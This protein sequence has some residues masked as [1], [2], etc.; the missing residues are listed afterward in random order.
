MINGVSSRHVSPN[1]KDPIFILGIL[2]RSGTNFL[3]N[4]L[5]L[6]PNCCAPVPV[7]EDYLVHYS[8]LLVRYTNT[9]FKR[10][11]RNSQEV[12]ARLADQFLG[13]L[14]NGM[15]SLLNSL[16]GDKRLVTKTPS[17]YNLEYFFKLFPRARLLIIVR[18]GRSLVESAVVSFGTNYDIAM[19]KWAD[20][21]HTILQFDQ[22]NRNSPFRYL[23]V[24]YE[25]LNT[26]LE[27][28]MGRILTY[29][30]L[31]P[32][33]YDFNAAVNLP[34][35]GSSELRQGGERV[36]HWDAVPKTANFNPLGRW[37]KWNRALHERFNW[38]AGSYQQQ[39]G[40]GVK[41]YEGNRGLWAMWN[42]LMDIKL[43]I[44]WQLR[45][46]KRTSVIRQYD[47]W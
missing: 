44:K 36:M 35:R 38:I 5:L 18:D 9:V 31:N 47:P 33:I 34:V 13:S 2:E 1:N 25:D 39:L 19:R 16:V 45:K 22:A 43:A 12:D 15:L 27:K 26:N 42:R 28:E 6:H 7:W 41:R 24:K 8:N 29:V 32:G 14:G 23:I 4:L 30:D 40:Y 10:W 3:D 21:A 11:S 46:L 17:A 37:N 20:A